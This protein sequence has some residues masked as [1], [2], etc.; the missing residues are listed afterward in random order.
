MTEI[1][2]AEQ[3]EALNDL[4]DFNI[5]AAR[6]GLF[7][8]AIDIAETMDANN[9]PEVSPIMLTAAVTFTAQLWQQMAELSG[10]PKKVALKALLTGIEKAFNEIHQRR[11]SETKQ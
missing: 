3:E 7:N 4:L 5:E 11:Q 2:H 1:T 6:A 10:I 9:V 8:S